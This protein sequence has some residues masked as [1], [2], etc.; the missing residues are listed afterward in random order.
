MLLRQSLFV[1]GILLLILAL[2]E[3][4]L[5]LYGNLP[6]SALQIGLTILEVLAGLGMIYMGKQKR[7]P[8]AHS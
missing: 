6:K 2:V 3:F 1:I 7:I 8:L 5:T 4:A